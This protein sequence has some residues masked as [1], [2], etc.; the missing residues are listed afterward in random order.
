MGS[1]LLK[2]EE[3]VTMDGS[4]TFSFRTP[5]VSLLVL[6]GW[7]VGWVLPLGLEPSQG[8]LPPAPC[9]VVSKQLCLRP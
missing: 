7:R 4:D 9:L 3:T 8:L 2:F 6:K 1:D 5:K